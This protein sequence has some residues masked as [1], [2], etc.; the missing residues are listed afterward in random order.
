MYAISYKQSY[1]PLWP[2]LRVSQQSFMYRSH[3][4]EKI[5]YNGKTSLTNLNNVEMLFKSLA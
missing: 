2:G 5:I 4:L 3:V 1:L